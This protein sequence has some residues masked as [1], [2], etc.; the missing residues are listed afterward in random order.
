MSNLVVNVRGG[1]GTG[2]TTVM[3]EFL[4]QPHQTLKGPRVTSGR[5]EVKGYMIDCSAWGIKLPVF[6]VGSYEVVCGGTDSIYTQAEVGDRVAQA[7]DTGGHVLAEGLLM[8]KIGPGG[9]ISNRLRDI[10]GEDCWFMFLDT[11]DDV[12][13]ARVLQR[14]KD[15]GNEAPFDVKKTLLPG[16]RQARKS[17][18]LLDEKGGYNTSWLKY[19]EEPHK[20]V[21]KMLLWAESKPVSINDIDD[22]DIPF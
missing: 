8:S 3:R 10:G 15:A 5:E 18:V 4:K 20:E 21:I 17:K 1:S 22:D 12:C 9:H 6:L 14:R 7:Y 16:T 19:D 13:I 11:P 2:K